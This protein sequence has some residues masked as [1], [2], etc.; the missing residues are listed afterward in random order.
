[1]GFKL[2]INFE[3]PYLSTSMTEFFR[4]WH[5]SLGN[6]FKNYIYIPLGGNRKGKIR[7]ILNLLVVWI[8]TGLW[9]GANYNFIL[10]AFDLYV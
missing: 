10:G 8:L 9:H 7:T 5:I 3:T 1:M 4:R 6:W 2:P